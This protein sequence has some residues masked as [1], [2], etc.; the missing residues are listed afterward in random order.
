M[1]D[2]RAQEYLRQA[3]RARE[4]ALLADSVQKSEW[5]KIANSWA[6]LA[7]EY[8]AFREMQSGGEDPS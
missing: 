8:A 1:V 3:T 7:H 6:I 4:R 5:L 2:E